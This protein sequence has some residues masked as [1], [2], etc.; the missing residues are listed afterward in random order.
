MAYGSPYQFAPRSGSA[1]PVSATFDPR[2]LVPVNRAQ[3]VASTPTQL[4][5]N[6]AGAHPPSS[7]AGNGP[8]YSA[9]TALPPA[10]T[11]NIQGKWTQNMG[12]PAAVVT[13]PPM[14]PPVVTVDPTA[15]P[16]TVT[17]TTAPP[18]TTPP[19]VTGPQTR[20]EWRAA[21]PDPGAFMSAISAA[22]T[23]EERRAAV[24]QFVA[25]MREWASGFREWRHGERDERRAERE[26]ERADR[27]AARR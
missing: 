25:A 4:Y 1:V 2:T 20:E 3:P 23:S 21:R 11:A 27:L 12:P 8:A 14:A 22:S 5:E 10:I 6:R 16:E 15:P 13:D 26:I 24:E 7:F 19:A 9:T 18:T 17:T